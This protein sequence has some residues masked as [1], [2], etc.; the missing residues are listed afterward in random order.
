MNPKD[1]DNDEIDPLDAFMNDIDEQVKKEE[2]EG[3]CE[4]S[5][6]SHRKPNR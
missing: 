5:I 6:V 4:E 2:K 3:V 1:S